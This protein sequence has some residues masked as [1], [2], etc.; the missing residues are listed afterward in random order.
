MLR[1]TETIVEPLVVESMSHSGSV[2]VRSVL[3]PALPMPL[4]TLHQPAFS[5]LCSPDP[6]APPAPPPTKSLQS[7]SLSSPTVLA[8]DHRR[9]QTQ[10]LSKYTSRLIQYG[11]DD[12]VDVRYDAARI[13]NAS[14]SLFNCRVHV[15]DF[16]AEGSGATKKEAKHKA[17]EAAFLSIFKS[18]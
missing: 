7:S 12:K 3:Q 4:A 17:S 16:A 1:P 8:T 2:P 5:A 18:T 9:N 14:P 6:L 15:G 10:E 11:I 13:D